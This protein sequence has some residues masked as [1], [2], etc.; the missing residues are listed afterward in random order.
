MSATFV[1]SVMTATLHALAAA[2]RAKLHNQAAYAVW[3]QDV[4]V[5]GHGPGRGKKEI[6]ERRSLLPATD[7]GKDV[8]ARWREGAGSR[9]VVRHPN[10][11]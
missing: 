6:V 7:P 8:I 4:A 10:G 3:R 9:V 11:A 1:R 2:N 5:H